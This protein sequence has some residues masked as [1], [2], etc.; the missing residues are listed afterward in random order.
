[1]GLRYWRDHIYGCVPVRGSV[2]CMVKQAESLGQCRAWQET[3]DNL[4]EASFTRK[5]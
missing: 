4:I 5:G 2:W 1:M 3:A